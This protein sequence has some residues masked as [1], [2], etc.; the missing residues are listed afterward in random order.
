M[1]QFPYI[2]LIWRVHVACSWRLY[3]DPTVLYFGTKHLPYA[4]GYTFDLY[5]FLL[6]TFNR[7]PACCI[8]HLICE[9]IPWMEQSLALMTFQWCGFNTPYHAISIEVSTFNSTYFP[10]ATMVLIA[11]CCHTPHKPKFR[12]NT[13]HACTS[14]CRKCMQF[15]VHGASLLFIASFL[16]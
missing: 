8:A 12:K 14:T 13:C 9:C 15:L 1:G 16:P 3:N 6:I 5:T 11:A 4:V 2:S 7:N 10:I